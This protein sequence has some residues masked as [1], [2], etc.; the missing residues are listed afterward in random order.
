MK[1]I[2]KEAD[3]IEW[4]ICETELEAFVLETRLIQEQRPKWNIEGAFSFLY[5]L[6]GTT[7]RESHTYFC[8]TTLP[9]E[10]P[11]FSL[12]GAYRSRGMTKEAFF[13]WMRLLGYI[14]HPVSKRELS[15]WSG[16]KYSYVYGFRQLPESWSGLWDL[17]L[18]GESFEALE[19]LSLNLVEN[20]A[21][22]ARAESIQED[23]N[24]LKRFWRHEAQRLKRAR[25]V[26]SYTG[27]PVPQKERDVLFIEYRQHYR[28]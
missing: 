9:E 12:H 26:A 27:Y 13:A 8:F 21:A 24:W 14:G 6:I 19:E 2:I 3:K 16:K 25:Q 22:R 28:G 10:F 1:A 17:F 20:A 18:K 23:L 7:R 5:P 15:V 11:D 4:E